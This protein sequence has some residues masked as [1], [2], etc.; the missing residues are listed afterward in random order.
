MHT[1]GEVMSKA[2]E[3]KVKGL[4]LRIGQ[5]QEVID[6]LELRNS[7]K[8]DEII[9]L[10]RIIEDSEP[11][12]VRLNALVDRLRYAL[13]NCVCKYGAKEGVMVCKT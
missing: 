1:D 12:V 4:L 8:T 6:R 10:C 11:E 13:T 3:Q 2:E 5:L 9:R 7:Q